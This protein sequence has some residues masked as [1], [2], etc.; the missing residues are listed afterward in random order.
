[1]GGAER[2]RAKLGSLFPTRLTLDADDKI[3]TCHSISSHI[4]GI[5]WY[6]MHYSC[7]MMT[8]MVITTTMM[9]A[10]VT[11]ITIMTMIISLTILMPR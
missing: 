9:V 4:I 7:K 5:V 3:H 10:I 11:T 1:M 8:M 2:D 6:I